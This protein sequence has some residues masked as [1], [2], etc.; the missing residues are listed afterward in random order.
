MFFLSLVADLARRQ[1]EPP[2]LQKQVLE[3]FT[4][5]VQPFGC[6]LSLIPPGNRMPN[7]E[8]LAKKSKC[9]SQWLN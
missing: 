7:K 6:R 2:T 1:P 8:K 9:A 5:P 4:G 3:A